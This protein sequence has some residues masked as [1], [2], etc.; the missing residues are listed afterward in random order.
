MRTND[1]IYTESDFSYLKAFS[2]A[3][4]PLLSKHLC[5]M[6]CD[7]V[8]CFDVNVLLVNFCLILAS[9]IILLKNH[10]KCLHLRNHFPH[11]RPHRF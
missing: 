10:I 11:P 9:V 8:K 3:K 2:A 6:N 7:Q 1:T 5:F 4:M